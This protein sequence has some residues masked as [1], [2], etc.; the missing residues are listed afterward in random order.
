VAAHLAVE[1]REGI[2]A[3]PAPAAVESAVVVAAALQRFTSRRTAAGA[4]SEAELAETI[5]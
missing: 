5:G 3:A 4:D 2:L 1:A